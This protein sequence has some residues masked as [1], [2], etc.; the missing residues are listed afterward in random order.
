M[1]RFGAEMLRLNRL[2]DDAMIASRM[3]S[4]GSGSVSV[5]NQE[6]VRW[7]RARESRSLV[8]HILTE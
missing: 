7:R 2:S 4:A 3:R 1:A 5:P 8:E 6:R